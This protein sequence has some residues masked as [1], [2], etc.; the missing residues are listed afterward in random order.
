MAFSSDEPTPDTCRSKGKR[1]KAERNRTYREQMTPEQEKKYNES[2]RIRM[3]RHRK[4]KKEEQKTKTRSHQKVT[5]AQREKWREDKRASRAKMSAKLKEDELRKR[6][7]NYSKQKLEK[8]KNV[9]FAKDATTFADQICGII[10]NASPRKKKSL[11]ESG[12]SWGTGAH[13]GKKTLDLLSNH[14]AVLKGDRKS[15]NRKKFKT[16]VQSVC[17]GKEDEKLRKYLNVR[18]ST[19]KK[20]SSDTSDERK[21]RCDH[22]SDELKMKIQQFYTKHA[23]IISG[24]KAG[25]R[26]GNLKQDH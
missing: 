25:T 1:S 11:R 2:A 14:V 22:V 12:L 19:W 8:G 5:D 15:V 17:G 18:Y 3:Q 24:K 20:Y 13:I 16:V 21:K 26:K 9:T 6:R 10:M 23:T 4:K 7:E